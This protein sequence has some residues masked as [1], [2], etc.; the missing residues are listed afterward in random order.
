MGLWELGTKLGSSFF[1]NNDQKLKNCIEI[2]E[3]RLCFEPDHFVTFRLE[4]SDATIIVFEFEVVVCSVDFDDKFEF[5]AEEVDAVVPNWLL[6]A[7]F[8]AE[9]FI[10]KVAPEDSLWE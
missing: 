2:F 5:G 7:E 4:V 9:L 10:F 8:E 1:D 6:S 3:D